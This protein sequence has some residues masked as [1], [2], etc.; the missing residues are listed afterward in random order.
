MLDVVIGSIIFLF[1]IG[2]TLMLVFKGFSGINDNL[3][4]SDFL[5]AEQKATLQ[6]QT[7]NYKTLWDNL[8][9][10]LL[11]GFTIWAWYAA[12]KFNESTIMLLI[13]IVLI[14]LLFIFA[15]FLSNQYD[16]TL[17]GDLLA[18]FENFFPKMN[19]VLSNL[20]I[21]L[22]VQAFGGLIIGLLGD[23]YT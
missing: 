3:Q 4:D 16:D 18:G 1:I 7:D 12:F 13:V 11:G 2:L 9:I 5:P 19:W 21:V 20:V 22:F 6:G 14:A 8:F 23:R 10:L 17:S 15:A